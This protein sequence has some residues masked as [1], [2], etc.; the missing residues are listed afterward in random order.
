MA[1]GINMYKEMLKDI[2]IYE[3]L[4]SLFRLGFRDLTA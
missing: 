1:V 3:N 2:I 4:L